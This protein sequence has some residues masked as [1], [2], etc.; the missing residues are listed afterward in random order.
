MIAA[1]IEQ[2]ACMHNIAG[3]TITNVMVVNHYLT[4]H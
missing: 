2:C 4:R 1:L 3:R